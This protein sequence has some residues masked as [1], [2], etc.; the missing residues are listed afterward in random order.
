MQTYA[1]NNK[2]DGEKKSI[3]IASKGKQDAQESKPR[4][5]RNVRFNVCKHVE[6]KHMQ[7]GSFAQVAKTTQT[8]V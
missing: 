1:A 8:C 7:V 6:S 2:T 5:M 4:L 3:I